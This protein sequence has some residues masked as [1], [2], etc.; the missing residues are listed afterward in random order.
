MYYIPDRKACGQLLRKLRMDRGLSSR[1]A[2]RMTGVGV[3]TI[4]AAENAHRYPRMVTLVLLLNFY[5]ATAAIG[6]DP[7]AGKK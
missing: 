2:A 5:G 4:I 7:R 6:T 3:S 1:E